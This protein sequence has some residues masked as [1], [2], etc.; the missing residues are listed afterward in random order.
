MGGLRPPGLV[1]DGFYLSDVPQEDA[2]FFDREHQLLHV[3]RPF[4]DVEI[5]V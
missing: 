2:W 1:G 5:S 4:P 3:D